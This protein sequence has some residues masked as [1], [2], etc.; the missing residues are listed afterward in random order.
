MPVL[1]GDVARLVPFPRIRLHSGAIYKGLLQPRMQCGDTP[2][3]SANLDSRII[4]LSSL[5]VNTFYVYSYMH[6]LFSK[7]SL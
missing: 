4:K 5:I 7:V 1:K 2:N 3:F 6:T